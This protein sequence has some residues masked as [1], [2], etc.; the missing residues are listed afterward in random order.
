MVFDTNNNPIFERISVA[1]ET[2]RTLGSNG[3][4]PKHCEKPEAAW[5]NQVGSF[6]ALVGESGNFGSSIC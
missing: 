5:E 4:Q 6:F 3:D 1:N 2:S